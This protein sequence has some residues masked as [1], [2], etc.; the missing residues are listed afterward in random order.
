MGVFLS[1]KSQ[2]LILKEAKNKLYEQFAEPLRYDYKAWRAS[3]RRSNKKAL[4]N[5]KIKNE[6]QCD[7]VT[8]QCASL[9]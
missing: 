4:L 5:K 8:E 3:R 6:D 9:P 1:F 2:G 7:S